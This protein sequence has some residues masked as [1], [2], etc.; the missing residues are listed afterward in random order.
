[1]FHDVKKQPELMKHAPVGA[2]ENFNPY[3][4]P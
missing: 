2:F 1:M 4:Q 3:V